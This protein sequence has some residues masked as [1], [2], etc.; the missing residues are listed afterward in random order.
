MTDYVTLLGAEQVQSAARQMA[1]AADE[2]RRAAGS[3]DDSLR[4]HQRFLEDWLLRFQQIL[5]A[6][7]EPDVQA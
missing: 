7:G 5:E 6:K 4:S 3:I 2:M 1:S